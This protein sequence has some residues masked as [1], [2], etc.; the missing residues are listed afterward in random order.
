MIGFKIHFNVKGIAKIYQ[1]NGQR[2]SFARIITVC[3]PWLITTLSSYML[4]V[5]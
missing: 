5:I 1:E 3:F 4:I 2:H